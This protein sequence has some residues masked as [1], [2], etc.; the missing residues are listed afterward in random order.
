MRPD[1]ADLPRPRIRARRAPGRGWRFWSRRGASRSFAR[2][3]SGATGTA[4]ARAAGKRHARVA[5]HAD[6]LGVVRQK[7]AGLN[8]VGLAVPVGRI[9]L[10]QLFDVARLADEYGN[11]EVRL[12]TAQNVIIPERA[13]RDGWQRSSPSRCCGSCRH[14]P[15]GAIRGLVSCTGIDYCH[16]ALIETKELA[17]KTA[18]HLEQRAAARQEVHDALV[19]LSGRMRQSRGRGHRPARQERPGRRRDRRR[20]RRLRRRAS[21][22]RTRS[23]ARRFSKTCRATS[24]R[25]CSSG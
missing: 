20:G 1:H 15:P 9:T 3:C 22:V 24:C 8:Y 14:D 12:T 21:P 7:Q 11:G 18:R 6:H 4:A 19:G 13:G 2:S 10:D 5:A 17:L 23:P 25:K 16:F